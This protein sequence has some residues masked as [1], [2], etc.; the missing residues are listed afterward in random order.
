M[1][2]SAVLLGSG[3]AGLSA[4]PVPG[5]AVM[6]GLVTDEAGNPLAG[7]E[8]TAPGGGTVRTGS[9][10]RFPVD[11]TSVYTARKPGHLSRAAAG[12]PGSPLRLVLRGEEGS[13]SMRFGGDVMFG[14]RFYEAIAGH[15]AYLRPGASVEDHT[16]LLSGVAPLLK[17][18]DVTVVNLETPLVKDPYFDDNARPPAFHPTKDI[19]FGSALES[20]AALKQSGI[21]V[22]SMGNNHAAD[23]LGAGI[24]STLQALDAAQVLHMGAGLTEADA[25]K[26]ATMVV[27]GRTLAFLGCTTVDG[28]PGEVPIV[29]GPATPG[30]AKCDIDKLAS[31][32]RDAKARADVVTVMLHGE[33]EY[34]REQGPLIR[35]LTDVAQAAGARVVVNG[36]PHVVGGLLSAPGGVAAESMGNLLFDQ[37]VWS[38]QLGYL[39]RVEVTPDGT[40]VASTD[41][42]V[43]QDFLPVPAL[44]EVAD[45]GAR[46]A[47]GTVPG[48]ARL[49]TQG[50]VAGPAP[51]ET[52]F[53][54]Q[55]SVPA[56]VHRIA[57]GWWVSQAGDQVRVGQDLLWGTGSFAG[58]DSEGVVRPSALWTLGQF[59]EVAAAGACGDGVGL[60]LL[61]SP[62]SQKDAYATTRHRQQVTPGRSLSLVAEV[63]GASMG[64]S[65]ELKWY[66][67][68]S[69][70]SAGGVRIPVPESSADAECEVVRIDAE[71][72]AGVMA[73]QPYLR[74]SPPDSQTLSSSLYLDNV[75]LIEWAAPGSAGRLFD[76]VEAGPGAAAAFTLDAAAGLDAPGPLL[77]GP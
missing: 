44:G 72:P 51:T 40:P 1:L 54:T 56:G 32:V 57:P 27:R 46:I 4:G 73:A 34:Q 26:P 66:G 21:D 58:P 3:I 70:G 28:K 24:T 35:H 14:R 23:A 7:A 75:R 52:G 15:D 37:N 41:T 65:I 16:H 39:L 19:V 45:S 6:A 60:Q 31:A 71:V 61:R 5:P 20:A 17:D 53:T 13:V 2:V 49:G 76:S 74:L 43:L 62:V 30:A 59:A 67:D 47:A 77:G 50:A 22:V 42:I 38:T 8:V 33:V 18:S 55:R 36:H 29:A 64:G 25:W 11:R 63:R 69:G 48:A 9:D 10:G 68:N 12:T